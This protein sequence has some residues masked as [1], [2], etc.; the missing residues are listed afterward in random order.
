M[1]KIVAVSQVKVFC[2]LGSITHFSSLEFDLLI[3]KIEGDS[4]NNDVSDDVG[5]LAEDEE[6]DDISSPEAEPHRQLFS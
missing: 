2:C 4:V 1:C 3:R 5:G 6:Q